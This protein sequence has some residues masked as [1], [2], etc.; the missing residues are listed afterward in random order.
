[1]F[2]ISWSK[3]AT[4][5]CAAAA[6]VSFAVPCGPPE[7]ESLSRYLYQL[8]QLLPG[9]QPIAPEL[10]LTP[11]PSATAAHASACPP[12]LLPG[13]LT[14]HSVHGSSTWHFQSTT[15][16]K[17]SSQLHQGSA[18]LPKHPA[19]GPVQLHISLSHCVPV[20]FADLEMLLG[21]LRDNL[22]HTHRYVQCTNL[23]EELL[24]C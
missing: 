12:F 14:G 10:Q 8:Q 23:L 4:V 22:A 15:G 9:L 17:Q 21:L 11:P 6:S 16:Q 3:D 18:A 20:P 1:M 24:T 13:G 19:Q 7:L 5:H 2:L